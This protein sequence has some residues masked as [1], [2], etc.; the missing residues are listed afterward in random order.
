[1]D[2]ENAGWNAFYVVGIGYIGYMM[3]TASRCSTIAGSTWMMETAVGQTDTFLS[4][5]Q[6]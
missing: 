3:M 6:F 2:I 4:V 5:P 1:M